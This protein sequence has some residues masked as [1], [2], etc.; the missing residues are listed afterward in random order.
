MPLGSRPV[1]SVTGDYY[2]R[3]VDYANNGVYEEVERLGGVVWTPPLFADSLKMAALRDVVWSVRGRHPLN[4]AANAAF[5]SLI[6]TSELRI[7]GGTHARD[8]LDRSMDLMGL[9]MWSLVS[10][11]LDTRLPAGISAPL[12]TALRDVSR[13]A[14][15]VLNLITLNCS[16]GTVVTSALIRALKKIGNVPMLTLV[17][18]GLKKTNEKTRL[19]AFMEQVWDRYSRHGRPGP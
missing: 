19:E 13:G 15:G 17:Y 3:L 16:Y 6:T 11:H 7:K 1:I 12:A 14:D 8:A 18:D 10:E 9:R 4:A 2:T 5:L